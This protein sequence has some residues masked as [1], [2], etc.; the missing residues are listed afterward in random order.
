[1]GKSEKCYDI[2]AQTIVTFCKTSVYLLIVPYFLIQNNFIIISMLLYSALHP[3]YYS[4]AGYHRLSKI[5][6]NHLFY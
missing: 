2:A 1:L 3:N 5:A 6:T 4:L